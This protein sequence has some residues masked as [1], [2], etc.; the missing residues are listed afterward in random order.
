MHD[1]AS[2]PGQDVVQKPARVGSGRVGSGG[3]G[4]R[5]GPVVSGRV[6]RF[7]NISGPVT[8]SP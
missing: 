4:N 7:F 8:R 6:K 3:V 5:T 2:G 1:P